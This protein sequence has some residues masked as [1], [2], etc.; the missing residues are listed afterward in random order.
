[1]SPKKK[2]A[3]ANIPKLQFPLEYYN[4]F[5][6]NGQIPLFNMYLD[7]SQSSPM[8]KIFSKVDYEKVVEV[9]ALLKKTGAKAGLLLNPAN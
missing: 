9:L 5:T 2:V 8:P 1:M 3:S 6:L 7:D 4:E